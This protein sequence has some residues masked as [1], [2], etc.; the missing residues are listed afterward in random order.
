MP[1]TLCS[2]NNFNSRSLA[3]AVP[4]A[5]KSLRVLLNSP[6]KLLFIFIMVVSSVLPCTY[7]TLLF[8]HNYLSIISHT[9]LCLIHHQRL[10]YYTGIQKTINKYLLNK[11]PF[12]CLVSDIQLQI[13]DLS[14]STER[15]IVKCPQ[16][17]EE[18]AKG[19]FVLPQRIM[20]RYQQ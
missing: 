20:K 11:T 2:N 10:N 13:T 9:K 7:T 8:N 1:H 4:S 12:G 6:D 14:N 18:K 16:K 19:R 17:Q 15:L 3:Q 5:R